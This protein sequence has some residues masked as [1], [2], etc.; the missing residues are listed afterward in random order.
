MIGC[1]ERHPLSLPGWL[2]LFDGTGLERE[3]SK[4][5][6]IHTQAILKRA[7][8][9]FNRIFRGEGEWLHRERGVYWC[10]GEVEIRSFKRDEY[11][12]D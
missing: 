7:S 8:G 4:Q 6:D 9:H 5:T 10:S 12:K 1:K 3:G 2:P 11:N